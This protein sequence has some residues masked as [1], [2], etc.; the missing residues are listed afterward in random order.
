VNAL[1]HCFIY[2]IVDLGYVRPDAV[3]EITKKLVRGGIDLLQLRAKEVNID[4]VRRI[5]QAMVVITQPA[6]V[7][8]ILNDYP[9]LLADVSAEGCHLGQEDGSI[10][11][12]RRVAGR[13][14]IVG[15]STHSIEQALAAE[16]EGADYIGYGPLFPTPTK[17]AAVA[18]GLSSLRKLHAQVRIPIFCIGGIKESNLRKVTEA[19][20]E[21]VCIVSDL[22]TAADPYAKVR[23]VKAD[24]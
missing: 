19:G 15:R 1:E 10:V 8:F 21:R 11:D 12:A 2:G 18:I 24:L 7:P 13:P 17:P 6:G 9:Q 23:A 4:E 22:L 5:A 16:K 3:V 14:I 20:A